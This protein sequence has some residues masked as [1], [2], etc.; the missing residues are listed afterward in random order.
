VNPIALFGLQFT[1]SFVIFA[2]IAAW[3][4]APAIRALPVR[5]ALAPMFLVH[6]FRYLPSTAFAPGRCSLRVMRSST[7]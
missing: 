7:S 4:V 3:Y 6:A 2:L 1:L 5:T